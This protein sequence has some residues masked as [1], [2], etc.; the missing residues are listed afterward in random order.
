MQMRLSCHH[1]DFHQAEYL[2]IIVFLTF[3]PVLS[4]AIPSPISVQVTFR[5]S[6]CAHTPILL[7]TKIKFRRY[8]RNP[9]ALT[10]LL[11]CCSYYRSHFFPHSFPSDTIYP[12]TS[13]AHIMDNGHAPDGIISGQ[14][15]PAPRG[16]FGRT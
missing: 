13:P 2:S 9:A 6:S 3:R 14:T 16:I 10:L 11:L 12:T 5:K 1:H 7:A 15:K 4:I 8:F